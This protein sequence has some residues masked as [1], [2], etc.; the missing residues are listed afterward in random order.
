MGEKEN[1]ILT[2]TVGIFIGFILTLVLIW[3]INRND[4]PYDWCFHLDKNRSSYCVDL[5]DQATKKMQQHSDY[6]DAQYDGALPDDG[7]R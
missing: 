5:Y 7:F 4:K 1:N 2:L 3:F 6:Q